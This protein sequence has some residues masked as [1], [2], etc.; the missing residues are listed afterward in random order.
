V[1]AARRTA[2]AASNAFE[3]SLQRVLLE[4]GLALKSRAALEAMLTVD[5]ALRRLAGRLSALYLTPAALGGDARAWR[6]MRD[7]LVL[8]TDRLAQGM[9][10]IPPRPADAAGTAGTPGE[11]SF[12]DGPLSRLARPIELAAGAIARGEA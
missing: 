10:D 4:R 5:A 8:A 7:W 11:E 12:R 3:A 1:D 6:A 9:T 2:G